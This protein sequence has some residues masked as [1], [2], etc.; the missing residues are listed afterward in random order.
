MITAPFLSRS[1][2]D[3]FEARVRL[4]I[5]RPVRLVGAAPVA[6]GDLRAEQPQVASCTRPDC[7]MKRGKAA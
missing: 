4:A 6:F 5:V 3:R 1:I 7:P 2:G